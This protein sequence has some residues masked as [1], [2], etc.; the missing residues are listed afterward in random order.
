MRSA[1]GRVPGVDGVFSLYVH[2][3]DD[4]HVSEQLATVGIWEPFETELIRRILTSRIA[5]RHSHEARD[6]GAGP[7]GGATPVLFLDCGANIGWYSVLACVLGADVIAAEPL[8][9][10]ADLLA[11]NLE[12]NAPPPQHGHAPQ[13]TRIIRGALGERPGTAVLELSATNQGDHRL[14]ANPGG[15]TKATVEVPVVT[16]D[17]I[18]E[19]R[20]PDIIK[21]DTQGSEVAILRGGRS[22]WN[23]T[24]PPVLVIEFW[25]YGLQHCGAHHDD[26]LAML[27]ELI[28]VTHYCFDIVEWRTK[29][30][31]ITIGDLHEMATV[32]GFSPTMKGFTNLLLVPFEEYEV[33]A[34]LVQPG[35]NRL[36][37]T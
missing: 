11:L 35:A 16:V 8:P 29:L 24:P 31:P 14:T 26:L 17:S 37:E 5:G 9:R 2:E 36:E 18:V 15:T 19:G 7:R 21:I 28:G 34:D 12:T 6:S 23:A 22:A 20:V 30:A 27:D 13:S 1:T 10:N 3:N 32:G 25:P 33:I 4:K